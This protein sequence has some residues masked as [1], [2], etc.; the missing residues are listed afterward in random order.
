MLFISTAK[1]LTRF[2]TL[3]VCSATL[4]MIPILSASAQWLSEST[5]VFSLGTDMVRDA[6]NFLN[7]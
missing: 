3:A 7:S 1:P 6:L 5:Y 4:A 2:V